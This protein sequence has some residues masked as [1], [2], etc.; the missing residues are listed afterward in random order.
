MRVGY[1]LNRS[2]IWHKGGCDPIYDIRHV[3]TY[4]GSYIH[5]LLLFSFE[6]LLIF[7]HYSALRE[8]VAFWLHTC[9]EDNPPI[10]LWTPAGNSSQ[11][12]EPEWEC[13]ISAANIRDPE[14][15]SGQ[16]VGGRQNN[17][18]RRGRQ[19]TGRGAQEEY[20]ISQGIAPQQVRT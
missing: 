1:I 2:V 4:V 14:P 15:K 3:E 16:D 20:P 10:E 12:K 5:C 17:R 9:G 18:R 11:S 19:G 8:Q 7:A 13:G 6:Y